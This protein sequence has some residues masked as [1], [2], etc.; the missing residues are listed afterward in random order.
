MSECSNRLLNTIRCSTSPFHTTKEA[1]RQLKE[2]DFEELDINSD[3]DLCL[4][5]SYYVCPFGTTLIA[6]RLNQE[7]DKNDVLK[8][9]TAHIDNPGLRIKANPIINGNGY[10]KLNTEIYGGAIYSTWMDRPLSIAGRVYLKGNRINRP[11]CKLIDFK[12]PMAVIPN[13]AI[14]MNRK[15]NDGV[16]LNEQID[17][18]PIL[19]T[20]NYM[21]DAV[22]HTDNHPDNH[23]DSHPDNHPVDNPDLLY[24]MIADELDIDANDILS[25]ELCV[26]N[27]EPGYTFNSLIS[28]P[29]IDNISSVQACLTG[30][31]ESARLDG[32]DMIALFDHEEVGSRSKNGAGS[33]LLANIIEGI[34]DCLGLSRSDYL[35]A[36]SN[37]IFLSLDVAH[38]LN[39]NH[40]EKSD[41]TS[42]INL[43]DGV[44]LK[45]ASKQNY[46]GDSEISAILLGLCNEYNIP[47]KVNYIRSDQPGGSTLGSILSTSLPMRCADLGIPIL[48]M[49]SSLETMNEKDQESL[50]KLITIFYSEL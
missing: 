17:L 6:F 2:A 5:K 23:P 29:R 12:R 39:P 45:T 20:T 48:A 49:H 24:S 27:C 28:A 7:F 50:E 30:L 41:P 36:V 37:G 33:V 4:G 38:G 35:R 15:I 34:Y 40:A 21:T 9:T 44:A 22:N 25:A 43:G 11:I 42:A 46:C 26:Y 14:H 19:S 1:I 13:L 18:L 32:I 3:W 16:A 8:I 31:T 47:L 10:I